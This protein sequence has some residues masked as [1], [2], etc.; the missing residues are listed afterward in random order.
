MDLLLYQFREPLNYDVSLVDFTNLTE[1]EGVGSIV[2]LVHKAVFQ[3]MMSR[4]LESAWGW[5]VRTKHMFESNNLNTVGDVVLLKEG[6]V[7]R[8]IGCGYTTRKEVYEVFCM[9]HLRLK[10]W[11]PEKHRSRVNYKF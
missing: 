4:S 9:F 6:N 7:N 10:F 1:E 8:L 3:E 5:E 11:E 2:E